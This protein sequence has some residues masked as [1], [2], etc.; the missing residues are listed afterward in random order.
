VVARSAS[1]RFSFAEYL[2]LEEIADIKHEFLDGAND[3]DG[4]GAVRC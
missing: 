3:H 4:D 1:E 2:A